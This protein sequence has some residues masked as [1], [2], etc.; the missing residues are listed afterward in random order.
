[1]LALSL[2]TTS[3]ALLEEILDAWFASESSDES[4]DVANIRHVDEIGA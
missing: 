3:P 1:V 2:R 4:D